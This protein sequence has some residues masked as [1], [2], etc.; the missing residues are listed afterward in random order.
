MWIAIGTAAVFAAFLVLAYRRAWAWTGFKG[1]S[2]WDWLSLLVVPVGLALALF[3]LDDAQSR[4]ERDRAEAGARRAAATEDDRRRATLLSE[5]L[6]R[7]SDLLLDHGL[8]RAKPSAPVAQLASTLT[9]TVI[10]RLD[11]RR[12]AQVL[13]FLDRSRLIDPARAGLELI[14]ADFRG[15]DARAVGFPRAMGLRGVDFRGSNFDGAAIGTSPNPVGSGFAAKGQPSVI[16]GDFRGASFRRAR[17]TVTF[18]P[19]DLRGADLT[20]AALSR[21]SFE[22]CISGAR[23]RR[24]SLLDVSFDGVRGDRADFTGALMRGAKL[25]RAYEGGAVSVLTRARFDG[26]DLGGFRVPPRWTRAGVAPVRC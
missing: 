1:K 19:S 5:Y 25:V 18:G 4:R 14:G 11:G 6:E 3:L 10:G 20:A 23:F 16:Y 9:L 22:G 2:L 12:K 13:L 17:L 8:A 24:A 7:M 26:A 21:T 15:T